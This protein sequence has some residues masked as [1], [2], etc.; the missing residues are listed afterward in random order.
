VPLE[1]MPADALATPA[2]KIP[3]VPPTTPPRATPS[4][5]APEESRSFWPLSVA[6]IKAYLLNWL[7]GTEPK[8]A[9]P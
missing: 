3:P 7:G 6:T 2:E 8:T 9:T 1:K 4:A 5:A